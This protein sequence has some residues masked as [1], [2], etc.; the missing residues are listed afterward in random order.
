MKLINSENFRSVAVPCSTQLASYGNY[1]T[2]H[3]IECYIGTF[4]YQS[5]NAFCGENITKKTNAGVYSCAHKK[6]IL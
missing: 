5:R 6:E 4:K 1:S 2:A 3:T